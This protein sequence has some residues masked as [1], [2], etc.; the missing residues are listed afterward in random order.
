MTNVWANFQFNQAD[1]DLNRIA[2]GFEKYEFNDNS[3]TTVHGTTYEDIYGAS[4]SNNGNWDMS[5][6][7]YSTWLLAGDVEMPYTEAYV[8][9]CLPPPR[10]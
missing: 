10:G 9:H 5:N 4:F 8:G 3:N 7:R 1:V 2:A 6:T